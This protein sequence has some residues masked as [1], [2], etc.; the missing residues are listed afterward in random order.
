MS[1]EVPIAAETADHQ[2]PTTENQTAARLAL[3]AQRVRAHAERAERECE[4]ALGLRGRADLPLTLAVEELDA[5]VRPSWTSALSAAS[6][7]ATR[8]QLDASLWAIR[9]ALITNPLWVQAANTEL[10][11][12]LGPSNHLRRAV[13]AMEPELAPAREALARGAGKLLD[14]EAALHEWESRPEWLRTVQG[15][16]VDTEQ[17]LHQQ[18]DAARA[19]V[20]SAQTAVDEKYARAE[21]QANEAKAAEAAADRTKRDRAFRHRKAIETPLREALLA[22]AI[23]NENFR[24]H[25]AQP[26]REAPPD[27]SLTMVGLSSAPGF[28]VVVLES[29][30]ATYIADWTSLSEQAKADVQRSISGDQFQHKLGEDGTPTLRLAQ[31]APLRPHLHDFDG[32]VGATQHHNGQLVEFHLTDRHGTGRWVQPTGGDLL[33]E[34]RGDTDAIISG[35]QIWVEKSKV[36]LLARAPSLGV[37]P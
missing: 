29:P 16:F 34:L 19:E 24:T 8:D 18:V 28:T 4:A 26:L 23:L 9:D 35:N 30:T 21:A 14:A 3:G 37:E 32:V 17:R 31:C 20:A 27:L 13:G 7:D 5:L 12:E 22:R 15:W 11:D 25:D 2:R 33:T 10:G 1:P 6:H 36:Q